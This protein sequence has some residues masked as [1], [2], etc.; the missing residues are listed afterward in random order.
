[1]YKQSDNLLKKRKTIRI[2]LWYEPLW[3]EW[4][5]QKWSFDYGSS[6]ESMCGRYII[7]NTYDCVAVEVGASTWIPPKWQLV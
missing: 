1:M 3:L 6:H 5:T 7:L 2:I 4:L